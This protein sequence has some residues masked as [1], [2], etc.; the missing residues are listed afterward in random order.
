MEKL[1]IDSFREQIFDYTQS[2]DWKYKGTK[3][4]I[5]KFYSD[6]CSACKIFDPTFEEVSNEIPD[7]VDFYEVNTEEQQELAGMFGIRSIP[8]VVFIPTEGQPAMSVGAL[9]KESLYQAI[10]DILKVENKA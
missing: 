8:S 5:I 2:Q 4:A 9:P 7:K 3:P 6:W 10:S 1:G